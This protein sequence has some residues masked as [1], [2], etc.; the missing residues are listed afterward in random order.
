VTRTGAHRAGA[1]L[2]AL[3][4]VAALAGIA[5]ARP[6]SARYATVTGDLVQWEWAK[7]LTPGEF[8][9]T[10]LV[11]RDDGWLVVSTSLYGDGYLHAIPP[12][13]DAVDAHNRIGSQALGFRQLELR[14][15]RLFG[16]RQDPQRIGE[17][18][19][20]PGRLIELDPYSGEV[21]AD[22]GAWWYQDLAVDP[23]TEDLVLQSWGPMRHDLVRFNP[24]RG[25]QE[26]LVPD[27]EP[28]A[29]RAFEVAFSAD[30]ELLF[31]ANVTDV[32]PSVDVR[33]RD[34]TR[35]HSL[36]T[37]PLDAMT[38]GRP[39]SCFEGL[40]LFTRSDGSAWATRTDNGSA[41]TPLASAGRAF[42]VSYAAD[43]GRGNLATARYAD[44][45]LVACPGFVPPRA[46]GVPPA[47]APGVPAAEAVA[48]APAGTA[49]PAPA[50][51]S[52]PPAAPPPQPAVAPPAPP[53]PSPVPIA[54]PSALGSALQSAA[55]PS[56]GAADSPDEEH[57][58]SVAAS[59]RPGAAWSIGAVVAMALAS[60]ALVGPS[61][62]PADPHLA[63]AHA[64]TRRN[65]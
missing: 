53:A 14:R 23:R 54:P 26:V 18:V 22:H 60:F 39:G 36:Q 7:A 32:S 11:V 52:A 12:W 19:H 27:T 38:P 25:T 55:A 41:P 48:P 45:T 9:I 10:D 16:L 64:R 29:D 49:A 20:N 2:L 28:L 63:S 50:P 15:G 3:G 65:P 1:L 13:G 5:G 4:L 57:T 34:G 6:A 58:T 31:T 62:S 43:D 59:Y 21:V 42:A 56:A 40:L 33:R 61:G 46:P 17:V 35:L 37:G 44:V 51:A 24:E 8:Q 47:A 30:G